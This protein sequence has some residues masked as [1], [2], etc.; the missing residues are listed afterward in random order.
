M[1]QDQR[2][3]VPVSG[4]LMDEVDAEAVEIGAELTGRVQCPLLCVPIEA[5]GPICKQL[6]EVS[7][8]SPLLPGSA[9]CLIRPARVTDA[10]SEVGQ[11]L[12]LDPDREGS[13]V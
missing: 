10:L 2:N 4:P 12:G 13:D 5:V 9:W 7:K 3:A 11:D 6:P 8:V 1:G